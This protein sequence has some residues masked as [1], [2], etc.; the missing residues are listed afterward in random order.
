M[1]LNHKVGRLPA[2]RS[3]APDRSPDERGSLDAVITTAVTRS[4]TAR[5]G[6]TPI[7]VSP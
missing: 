6:V 2:D 1:A 4:W 7:D 5:A 3:A